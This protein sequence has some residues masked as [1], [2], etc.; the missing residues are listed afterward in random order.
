M[1]E[2]QNRLSAYE[3]EYLD[4]LE[5]RRGELEEWLHRSGF[6]WE[7]D[8]VAAQDAIIQAAKLIAARAVE[9]LEDRWKW[10]RAVAVCKGHSNRLRWRKSLPLDL[11]NPPPL[12]EELPG[13]SY[14]GL[15][16]DPQYGG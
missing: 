3:Q 6:S 8:M 15:L 1:S 16:I 13:A 12:P 14:W 11:C 9:T 4:F 7:D 10:L 5:G 2:Y